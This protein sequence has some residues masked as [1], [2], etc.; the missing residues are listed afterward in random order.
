A[1]YAAAYAALKAGDLSTYAA[2]MIKV[3]DLLQQLNT[4]TAGAKTTPSAT[5]SSSPS[6]SPSPSP[7]ASASP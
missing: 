1:E 2:D 7:S 5:P 3:G 6:S 4:L